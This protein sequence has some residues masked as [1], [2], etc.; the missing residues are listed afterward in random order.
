MTKGNIMKKVYA[1]K[2]G[3]KCDVVVDTWAECKRL[4]DGFSGAKFKGFPTQHEAKGWLHSQPKSKPKK[5]KVASNQQWNSDLYPCI[6]RKDYRDTLTGVFYKN[7]CIRRAGPT[8][9]GDKYKPHIG[10]SLPW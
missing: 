10:N 1:V 3:F 7:R 8:V 5:K 4:V 9:R 2:I 6:E